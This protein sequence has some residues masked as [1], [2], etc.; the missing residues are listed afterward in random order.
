MASN[1]AGELAP[2]LA[3][4][5]QA[6]AERSTTERRTPADWADW[7]STHL[8][9]MGWPGPDRPDADAAVAVRAWR[10][11]LEKFAACGDVTGALNLRAARRMLTEMAREE[12]APNRENGGGLQLLSPVEALGQQF[13]GL[14]VAGLHGE[15]WPAPMRP[16]PLIPLSLQR[17]A[18]VPGAAPDSHA[19][20]SRALMQKLWRAAGQVIVSAAH[21]RGDERLTPTPALAEIPAV[22]A[23]Q[24]A[25]VHPP[26]LTEQIALSSEIEV[27]ADPA[28]A[29]G[30]QPTLR[31]GVRLLQL[32]ALCPARAFFEL[33]LHARELVTPSFG[34]DPATRGQLVHAVLDKLFDE[35]QARNLQPGAADGRALVTGVVQDSLRH[36][37]PP[38]PL[39]RVLA[40]LEALRLELL[41]HELLDFD[42][43]RPAFQVLAT[44]AELQVP[45]GRLQLDLRVDRIDQLDTGDQL[46]ID[47]KTGGQK[48]RADWFGARPAE[49]QL[50]LYA[51]GSG[52]RSVAYVRLSEDGIKIDGIAGDDT[53]IDGIRTVSKLTRGRLESWPE[54]VAEWQAALVALA[55]EFAAGACSIDAGAP[56]LAAGPYAPLTRVYDRQYGE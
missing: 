13:D 28:P 35:L 3:Q 5:L 21:R 23:A 47:Y 53:G 15:A 55:E 32:Q 45:L 31:G 41:V 20:H 39:N 34:I 16:N 37:L 40:E 18:G 48:S 50:P 17:Q 24:L 46:V 27:V 26:S 56:E 10:E 52:A 11:L 2:E 29:L 7:I 8:E 22:E 6:I 44:E 38:T 43:A 14:W 54:L 42:A 36:R 33:R 19:R 49:P 1:K 9:L 51:V 12:R 25:A 30:E 4:R